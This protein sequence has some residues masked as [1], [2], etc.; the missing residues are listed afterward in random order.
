MS[1][2]RSLGQ[3]AGLSSARVPTCVACPAASNPGMQVE[4]NLIQCRAATSRKKE[5]VLLSAEQDHGYP[6][7]GA[8][9][10]VRA[11]LSSPPPASACRT[12]RAQGARPH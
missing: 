9:T 7:R 11:P 12:A 4:T 8:I 10:L 5:M 6:E 2:P 1:S 3:S